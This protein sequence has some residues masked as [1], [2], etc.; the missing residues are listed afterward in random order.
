MILE[1]NQIIT[2]HTH[3]LY[4]HTWSKDCI[5]TWKTVATRPIVVVAAAAVKTAV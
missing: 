2:I 4:M 5:Q 1:S 3:T